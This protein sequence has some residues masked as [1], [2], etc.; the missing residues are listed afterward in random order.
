MR[1]FSL[2]LESVHGRGRTCS[3]QDRVG[4]APSGGGVVRKTGCPPPGV[5]LRP[6]VVWGAA[7]RQTG[8]S[9]EAALPPVCLQSS[10]GPPSCESGALARAG[11][12]RKRGAPSQAGGA[13]ARGGRPRK[14]GAPS[15][16]GGPLARGRLPRKR[17]APPQEGGALAR[18]GRPR[19][20]GAPSQEGGALA[21]RVRPRKRGAPSQEGGAPGARFARALGTLCVVAY[22]MLLPC[23]A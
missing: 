16:E 13:L 5:L 15:Q 2:P 14:W 6:G 19:K 8:G 4:V 3:V 20:R 10:S 22:T 1:R 11:R 17:A 12:P 18:T 21:R 23:C 7:R 9:L